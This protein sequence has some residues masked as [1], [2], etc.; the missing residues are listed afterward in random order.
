M[1]VGNGGLGGA[2]HGNQG[3]LAHVGEACQPHV[4]QKLQLQLQLEGFTGASGLGEAGDLAGSG[5][6]V[7]VARAAP[8]P[9]GQ[10]HRPVPGEI[11]QEP[12]GSG[13][14]DQGALGD[15]D[16]QAFAAFAGAPLRA[17]G[18]AVFRCEFPF[19]A[20]VQQGGAVGIRLE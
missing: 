10:H 4:C 18:P 2:H 20:E 14:P 13:F 9:T 15:L 11:S 16:H 12:P 5:G 17:P 8:S 19:I 1:I 3:G 6:K 7:L